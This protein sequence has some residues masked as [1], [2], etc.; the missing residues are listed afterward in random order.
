MTQ[1]HI[2][3]RDRYKASPESLRRGMRSSV[4]VLLVALCAWPLYFLYSYDTI[5]KIAVY[6]SAIA[7]F[8]FARL[9]AIHLLHWG[10][11]E[12]LP[13]YASPF[14]VIAP[15]LAACFYFMFW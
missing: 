11:S 13:W 12:P 1:Q 6:S 2:T 7:L 5:L 10:E 8:M 3:D 14:V 9:V 15:A 4:L